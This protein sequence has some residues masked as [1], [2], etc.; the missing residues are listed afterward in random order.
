MIDL[1]IVIPFFNEEKNIPIILKNFEKLHDLK[2]VEIIM[3]NN[4]S[5][6]NSQNEMEKNKITNVKIL[7]LEKNKGYGGGILEGLK[8]AQGNILAWTHGDLQCDI[9]DV[10]TAYKSFKKIDNKTIVIKGK[11]QKRTIMEEI[12]TFG[13]QIFAS[14][15]LKVRLDDI[16]A[17][18]KLFDR[19]FFKQLMKFEPPKD[20]S[21][22]LFLLYFAIKK[23]YKIIN[24]PI[25]FNIRKYGKAKGGGGSFKN[26]FIIV[27]RTFK[28]IIKLKN[29]II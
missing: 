11:R 28:Y 21:L 4:G 10:I 22:D 5:T 9:N 27:L 19:N 29:K 14:I 13:M 2:F 8:I 25:Y 24:F 3:V 17:Q 7:N 1:S 20:F 26:K 12:L 15:I 18:P 16:N 6:D 23:N